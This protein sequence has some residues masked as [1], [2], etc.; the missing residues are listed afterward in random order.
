M[1]IRR[2]LIYF[3]GIL[4]A[5]ILIAASYGPPPTG[6]DDMGVVVGPPPVVKE[7]PP[8]VL[9]NGKPAHTLTEDETIEF[10]TQ[11]IKT[12]SHEDGQVELLKVAPTYP[13]TILFSEPIQ[14]YVVGDDKMIKVE[15]V[16]GSSGGGGAGNTAPTGMVIRAT[17]RPPGDTVVQ[18]FFAGG[19]VRM[20]HIFLQDNFVTADSCIR[21]VSFGK[22]PSDKTF[23]LSNRGQLDVRA[24]TNVIRNYD[25]LLREKAIDNRLVKRTEVFRKSNIT[26][27]TTF[28]LYQFASKPVAISFAYQNPYPYPIRYDESRL[29]IA[30]GNVQYI[31]DYVSFHKNT[32]QPGETTTGFAIVARPAFDVNQSFE[33]VWK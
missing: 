16:G 10:L 5:N 1:F 8:E 25:A 26:S 31:P 32:L 17:S 22:S 24:I 2:S 29:R 14:M 28:Y 15:L 30:L 9:I 7:M 20:Y 12:I 21:V 4:F 6:D 33:L 3:W 11:K 23:G 27:F 13:L 19:K 18:V